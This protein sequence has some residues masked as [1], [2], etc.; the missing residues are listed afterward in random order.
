MPYGA[1]NA[2]LKTFRE[3]GK[4]KDLKQRGTEKEELFPE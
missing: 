1:G 2:G 3:E 4:G